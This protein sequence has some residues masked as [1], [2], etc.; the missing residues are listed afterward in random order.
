MYVCIYV[1]VVSV[2]YALLRCVCRLWYF[3][4]FLVLR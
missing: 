3:H 4:V 2:D 1:G